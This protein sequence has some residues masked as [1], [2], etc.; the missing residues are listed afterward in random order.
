MG[1][2]YKGSVGC[3]YDDGRK[4]HPMACG[5]PARFVDSLGEYCCEYHGSLSLIAGFKP[6]ELRSKG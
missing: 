2:V 5:V 3:T 1:L 4:G 6:K